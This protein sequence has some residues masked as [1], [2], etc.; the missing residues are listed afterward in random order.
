MLTIAISLGVVGQVALKYG[1]RQHGGGLSSATGVS[2][3]GN[4]MH[5]ILTPYVL[6][7]LGCYVVSTGFWLLVI[8]RWNLSYA[9]PMIAAG[10]I[11]LVFLS[12]A[13]FKEQVTPPQ[14]AGI[15]LLVSGLVLVAGFGSSS[16]HRITVPAGGERIEQAAPAG[17]HAPHN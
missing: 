1:M 10:Q 3:L 2:I 16:G 13:I 15:V 7:G 4:L 11:G 9:Y 12:R 8:S 6:L 14:W 5:A 17:S